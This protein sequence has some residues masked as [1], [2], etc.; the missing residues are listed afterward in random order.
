MHRKKGVIT[1]FFSLLSVVFLAFAFTIVEGVRL[2][3]AKAQ[4]TN[5]MAIGN[6]TLLSEYENPLLEKFDLFGI[7]TGYNS[8][9]FSR[10]YMQDIL[11]GNMT[12]N[13]A[14]A[15]DSSVQLPGLT[16]DPWRISLKDVSICEYALLSDKGGEYYYQQAVEF[17][18]QTAWMNA[19]DKLEDSFNKNTKI[20]SEQEQ[21]QK[22]K[23][24]AD[25]SIIGTELGSAHQKERDENYYPTEEEKRARRQN[26][27]GKI[28]SMASTGFLKLLC[29]HRSV[30]KAS[31]NPEDL[32]SKRPK[33]KGNLALATP[34]GGAGDNLLFR[35]YLLDHFPD[36]IDN[37]NT[38]TLRYQM[39][40]ILCGKISDEKNLK[41]FCQKLVGLREAV[42]YAILIN[43][44][45]ALL[46]A[47]TFATLIAGVFGSAALVEALKQS[48]LLLWAYG[49]SM[50]DVRMLLHD[51]RVPAVK[52]FNDW[53]IPLEELI[54]LETCLESADAE[55]FASTSGLSY[56]DYIRFFLNT[57]SINSQRTRS[58]DLIELNMRISYGSP[59][60]RVDNCVIGVHDQADWILNPVFSM[61][62]RAFLGIA[63]K[64]LT[65]K[66]EAGMKY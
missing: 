21:Y 17:M 59:S 5:L 34:R 38:G 14:G 20:I 1:V 42:N 43:T 19:L 25:T 62:P 52:T 33:N 32:A 61:V 48:L 47:Q 29:G 65:I 9:N 31:L 50:Y 56:Q 10:E 27:I 54:N 12:E 8:G 39:E 51:G 6:W 60:F 55:G 2:S 41:S 63:A 30:S 58:L 24:S 37:E 3:G 23:S 15:Q 46:E 7:D 11:K 4:C 22:E 64:P 57:S 66:V 13:S 49:E 36:F 35:E 44:P 53:H 28:S 45:E 26:P 16:F 40:Y 18:R